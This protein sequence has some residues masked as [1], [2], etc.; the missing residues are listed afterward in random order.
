MKR[1]SK[2]NS[3][4][5]YPRVEVIDITLRN[6]YYWYIYSYSLCIQFVHIAYL[7]NFG[8]Y[9]AY[10]EIIFLYCAFCCC[11]FD[12]RRGSKETKEIAR[13]QTRINT[14][15]F[16]KGYKLSLFMS[17][18]FLYLLWK[19][20]SSTSPAPERQTNQSALGVMFSFQITFPPAKSEP[21]F[22]K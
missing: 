19:R 8:S 18:A 1:E 15:V 3:K 5:C 10:L 17:C 4:L 9:I 21:R 22:L 16:C 14:S 12:T 13:D 11:C 7:E 6:V 2:S 20:Q